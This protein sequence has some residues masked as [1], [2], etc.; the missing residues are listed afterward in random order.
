MS[1]TG[2]DST[3][4]VR[5]R[6]APSPTGYLH[7]GGART[8]LYNFLYARKHGG[9]FIL[10]IEDTD[11]ERSTEQ[12]MRMQIQDLVWLGLNWDEG[13][14]P[15]T[16]KDRGPYGPYRQS[17]RTDI[18]MEHANRLLE[19]GKAYYDF[20]TDEELEAQK[21]EAIQ[22][23]RPHQVEA[24]E[25]V[26][27]LAEARRRV[28]AG[29]KA[30]IRFRIGE[31]REYVLQDLIRNEV[32]FPSEM[33]GDFVLLRSNGMPVYNFCCVVDDALMKITHVF[34]A[35]EHLSNTVRQMMIYEALGYPLPQFGHLSIILG[36]D[37][38]KLSKRHGAT[39]CH[40]YNERG[41][42]P[43]ALNNFIAL[44]GWSSP[45]GQEIISMA[46]LVEQFGHERLNAAAA[47]F[48]EQK[49]NWVNATHLRALDTEELWR[50]VQP[51][52][53]AAGIILPSDA[54]WR[55]RALTLFKSSMTTLA[56]AVA[57]FRPLSDAAF[58]VGEEAKDVLTWAETPK[59]WDAWEAGLKS[60][61]AEFLSEQDFVSLQDRVKDQ[62]GVK[63]KHLFMPIRVA[64]IGKPSGAELKELVP[65][66]PKSSLLKRV[67]QARTSL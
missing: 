23:G 15:V 1:V 54:G 18:Y 33:V 42:L 4:S 53:N 61:A 35:E 9:T 46:E 16:L 40:D 20:R 27:P 6:F 26:V 14:D 2:S 13:P 47:V 60:H 37:K 7:V 5:V 58:Q 29:E 17:Q 49:L 8:A 31:K 66:L 67:H 3:K 50:R 10:R 55:D 64:V 51:F 38:Q 19:A 24:P 56:D 59:V 36:A 22:A 34:R 57:L 48:D 39:S 12:S 45:K 43:E 30:A 44:L 41:Y 32:R 62:L 21:Q 63:G 28:A 11:L 65:L 52:L 25:Q